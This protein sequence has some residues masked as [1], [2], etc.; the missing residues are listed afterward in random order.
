M[1]SSTFPTTREAAASDSRD[2]LVSRFS[3][4]TLETRNVL[5]DHDDARKRA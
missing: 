3:S 4:D 5:H 2:D 1:A